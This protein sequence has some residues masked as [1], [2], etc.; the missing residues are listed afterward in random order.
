MNRRT[1]G[2]TNE[3]IDRLTNIQMHCIL[4]LGLC[5]DGCLDGG[6]A[7]QVLLS[8]LGSV[9][10]AWRRGSGSISMCSLA[11][12]GEAYHSEWPH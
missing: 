2:L 1:H 6:A 3:S 4:D 12:A 5:A 8:D 7:G 11:G 10:G 9:K